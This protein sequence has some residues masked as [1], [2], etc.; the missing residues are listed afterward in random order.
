MPNVLRQT[1]KAKRHWLAAGF[2]LAVVLFSTLLV[3]QHLGAGSSIAES[4]ATG[5]GA[6]APGWDPISL[7]QQ[8]SIVP[9]RS[10]SVAMMEDSRPP[11]AAPGG[12]IGG[13]VGGVPGGVDAGETGDTQTKAQRSDRQVVRTGT[14]NIVAADPVSVAQQVASIATR[15][16][17]FVV[18]STIRGDERSH[19]AAVQV[20]IPADRFDAARAEVRGLANNVEEDAVQAQDVTH[21]VL[22]SDATL[23][24]AR[25]EEEQYLSL[26]KRAG[27]MKDVLAV[28][29]KLADVRGRIEQEDTDLN[30]LRH[31]VEM[32][33]LS[34]Q[35]SPVPT[36]ERPGVHWRPMVSA[37]MSVISAL[38]AAGDFADSVL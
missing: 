10:R 15:L 24:N 8:R 23:R 27:S 35:I 18:N 38:D 11:A 25:A 13:I 26:L 33:L 20:R 16:G 1:W 2:L 32:S 12:A 34:V 30:Y 17:G 6:T 36:V 19:S 28:T 4:R 29:E 3:L 37:R 14:L 9:H 22:S 31:T 5:L 21:Q 7:W